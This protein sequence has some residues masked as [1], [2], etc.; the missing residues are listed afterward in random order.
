MQKLFI[1]DILFLWKK[2]IWAPKMSNLFFL[3]NLYIKKYTYW[4]IYKKLI[5]VCFIYL[6]KKTLKINSLLE[7][8]C[9][10]NCERNKKTKN[11]FSN[12]GNCCHQWTHIQWGQPVLPASQ[13]AN[14]GCAHL[15]TSLLVILNLK[16]IKIGSILGIKKR[17]KDTS[18]RIGKGFLTLW[19]SVADFYAKVPGSILGSSDN[20]F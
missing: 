8:N 19:P 5:V 15:R 4:K 16:N 2:S 3:Y 11:T 20:I 1:I 17:K 13:R 18:Y 14:S 10:E 7:N 6:K 12:L 9:W